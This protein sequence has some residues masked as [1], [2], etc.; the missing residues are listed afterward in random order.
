MGPFFKQLQAELQNSLPA[1][2]DVFRI[3]FNAGDQFFAG[4]NNVH[5]FTQ[6]QDQ[7]SN[8]LSSYIQTHDITH[9]LVYGDC[10][11]ITKWLPKFVKIWV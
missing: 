9:I 2:V 1:D 8:W 10:R 4:K 11:F 5:S 6:S 3:V 7:W